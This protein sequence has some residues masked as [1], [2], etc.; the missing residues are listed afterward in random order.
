MQEKARIVE[1]G[2]DSVT[3]IPVDIEAC[4]GCSNSECK[5]NGHIFHVVNRRR[6]DIKVGDTVHVRSPLKNQVGQAVIAVGIPVALA[7][8][9]F[10]LTPAFLPGAG[11]GLQ[12][13]ASLAALLAGSVITYFAGRRGADDMPEITEVL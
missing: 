13:G 5:D 12:V 10:I 8:C 9:V 4:I 1:I 6:H 7:V 11:E 2:K 3:V